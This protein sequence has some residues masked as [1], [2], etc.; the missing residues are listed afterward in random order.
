VFVR[1][2]A[3]TVGSLGSQKLYG[4]A[5]HGRGIS[6]ILLIVKYTDSAGF[7]AECPKPK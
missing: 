6:R 4:D 3:Q 1:G 7:G 2:I 5:V